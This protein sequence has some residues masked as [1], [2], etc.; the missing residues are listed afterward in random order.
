MDLQPGHQYLC[1]GVTWAS[2]TPTLLLADTTSASLA[3]TSLMRLNLEFKVAAP[4]RF[5]TGRYQFTQTFQVEPQACPHQAEADAGG[6]CPDCLQGDEFR[7]AHQF[8]KGGYT[9][10]A[11]A[12]Y[13]NQPH[14]LYIAT[15]ANA[16][17]KVGTAAATRQQSRLDEQGPM[18]ATYLTEVPDGRTVRHLEDALSRLLGLTQTVRTTA[19]LAALA[20]PDP[21]SAR[22][23]H[24]N[25]VTS[26]LSTLAEMGIR[27]NR[28][29]WKPPTEGQ[30]LQSPEQ[31]GRRVVYPHD[32]RTG[33]H[34][35]LIQSCSGSQALVRLS[36]DEQDTRYVLDLNILKG[37]RILIGDYTSPQT[38]HQA[39]L[40]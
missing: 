27:A 8:H 28:H 19:K 37:R 40:F 25:I 7:F 36:T 11:L 34:G 16:V 31:P 15:F 30:E 10:P 20:E 1:H 17:S 18:H 6:Q 39:S 13:M 9:P 33:E 22:I 26:A 24:E 38:T 35:L 2:G 3:R 29:E 5:C 4:A 14:L 21:A 12:T 32:L 23:T